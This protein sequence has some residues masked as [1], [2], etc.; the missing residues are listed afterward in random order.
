MT[1]RVAGLVNALFVVLCR[2]GKHLDAD[3]LFL[4]QKQRAPLR[5]V[6]VTG[7]RGV[8]KLGNKR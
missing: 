6:H 8:G 2:W 4:L 1:A 5:H 7:S 3:M